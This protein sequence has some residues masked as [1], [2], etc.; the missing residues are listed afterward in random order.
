MCEPPTNKNKMGIPKT[1]AEVDAHNARVLAGKLSGAVALK[2]ETSNAAPG[3]LSITIRGKIRGGKNNIIITRTGRRFPNP[4]WAKWRD[5]AVI[6]VKKQLPDSFKMICEPVNVRLDYFAG[7]KR[8]RDMPAIIDAIFHVLEK[9]G[10]VEDDTLLWVSKSTR[11]YN[12]EN[13]MARME[14]YPQKI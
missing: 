12:K 5:A 2:A 3:T 11:S 10:V 7:D 13:P 9:A 4:E 8:R 6:A 14:F 1:M